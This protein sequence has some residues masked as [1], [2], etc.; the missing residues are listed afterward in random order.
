[1]KRLLICF[2]L[3]IVLM[4]SLMTSSCNL[5][6][7]NIDWVDF[8][9]FNDIT[10][11]HQNSDVPLGHDMLTYYTEVRFKVADN[12][13]N[14]NY[15]IKNGDAAYLEKGT[16]LYSIKDYSSNFRLVTEQ[17]ELYEA[18]T[19]PN[20]KLGADLLAIG[21]KVDYIGINSSLDGKT[22]LASIRDSEQVTEL[23]GMVLKGRVDQTQKQ[24]GIQ[25]YFLE[26]HLKDGTT[27]NRSYWLDTGVLSRGIQLPEEFRQVVR[28]VLQ[29][30]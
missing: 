4:L 1:M 28:A 23:V 15:K 12:V 2:L 22:E 21:G 5:P 7:A 25:Q 9:K 20:A 24:T 26:F 30:P 13:N 16:I 6:I 8:I 17:G 3:A 10:Y 18:D 27:V 11:L 29:K 14:P 19:N